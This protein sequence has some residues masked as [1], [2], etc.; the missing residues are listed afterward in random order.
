MNRGLAIAGLV[1]LATSA[2]AQSPISPTDLAQARREQARAEAELARLEGIAARRKDR[3]GRLAAERRSAAAAIEAAEARIT[4]A[5][6][7]LVLEARRLRALEQ[8]LAEARR[9]VSAL[10]AGLVTMGERPPL[11]ALAD[12]GGIDELVRT[13]T[14][15]RAALPVARR[16]S[17]A[18][19]QRIA[20]LDDQRRVAAGALAALN[21]ERELLI[22]RQRRLIALEAQAVEASVAAGGAALIAGDRV[23]A[24]RDAVERSRDDGL[25]IAAELL[26]EDRVPAL[27]RESGA[28]EPGLAYRLP[29]EAPV[30]RGFG[31]V[32]RGGIR[33]RGVTLATAR[34]APLSAPADGTVRFAGPFEDYG[35]VVIVDHGRGWL[36]VLVNAAGARDGQRVRRGERLATALGA[37]DVELSHNGRHVSPA[38]IAGSSDPLFNAR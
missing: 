2:P 6:R 9:P 31:E 24:D 4:S 19:A 10:L 36:S 37:V 8:A 1:W 32:D 38:L 12:R 14:L 18:I 17:T 3:A 21:A 15:L 11:V 25:A 26:A 5:E 7:R 27:R 13:R 30:T 22:A 35:G 28:G 23:L 20:A 29:A 33:A 34:G 16:R